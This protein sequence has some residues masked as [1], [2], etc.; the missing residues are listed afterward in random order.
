MMGFGSLESEVIALSEKYSNIHF[1]KAVPMQEITKY[2]SSADIGLFFLFDEP[3]LSYKLSL[4]NKFS[5][6]MISGI[7]ILVSGYLFHLTQLVKEFNLGWSILPSKSGL[8]N[9]INS[10]SLDNISNLHQNII[11]YKCNVS[12]EIEEKQILKAFSVKY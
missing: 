6:Y 12:W 7:P 5:E 4:P 3:S 11:N 2:T 9:F 1:R 10:V 8:Q